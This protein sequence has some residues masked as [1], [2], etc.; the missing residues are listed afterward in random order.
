MYV[1]FVLFCFL[2]LLFV[3]VVVFLGGLGG[4]GRYALRIVSMDKILRL[5]NNY[6]YYC[7]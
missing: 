2:L 5:I 1:V 3:V 4:G 6:Y 7:Y